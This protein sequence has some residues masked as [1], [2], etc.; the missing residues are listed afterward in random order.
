MK[1]KTLREFVCILIA[2]L[3]IITGCEPKEKL[4]LSPQMKTQTTVTYEVVMQRQK[5]VDF[6]RPSEDKKKKE[7]SQAE[8]RMV[9]EQ[10]ERI[11]ENQGNAVY[12]I[13]IKSLSYFTETH[14]GV[15]FDFDSSR[16]ADAGHFL[17]QLLGYGYTITVAPSGQVV[18]VS[19][20]EQIRLLFQTA[21]AKNFVPVLLSDDAIIK[22]HSINALP[23]AGYKQI[24]A[25]DK[26]I[27]VEKP[28]LGLIM[29]KTFEKTYTVRDITSSASGNLVS[30]EMKALPAPAAKTEESEESSQSVQ[31]N[32]SFKDVFDSK[33][34]YTGELIMNLDSGKILKYSELLI[35]N[36]TAAQLPAS[37]KRIKAGPDILV[38]D[39]IWLH[40]IKALD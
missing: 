22:R 32:K 38:I 29:P 3:A 9:Y 6:T 24:S 13:K 35:S 19:N 34:D 17:N 30:I 14:E 37:P 27:Q 7:F 23:Q 2:V 20:A 5:S 31:I 16:Q 11:P 33:D 15:Q 40:S 4:P 21:P 1:N 39:L 28:Q 25:G 18:A 12:D 8:Y 10:T 36:N 26:W